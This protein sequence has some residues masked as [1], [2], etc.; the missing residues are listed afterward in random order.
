MKSNLQTLKENHY[1]RYFEYTFFL[2]IVIIILSIL[3]ITRNE[4]YELSSGMKV[5]YGASLLCYLIFHSIYKK[6]KV[7]E[8]GLCFFVFVIGL[9]GILWSVFA[10]PTVGILNPF[11]IA[12]LLSTVYFEFNPLHYLYIQMLNLSIFA[13]VQ[14]SLFF[15]QTNF[16]FNM[17]YASSVL[18]LCYLIVFNRYH[19]I[20]IA[21]ENLDLL[22]DKNKRLEVSNSEIVQKTNELYTMESL[23]G[24][25]VD[26][27]ETRDF[28]SAG[29]SKRVK[30]ISLVIGRQMGL[31]KKNLEELGMI[32]ILHDVGKIGISDSALKKAGKLTGFEWNEIKKHPVCGYNLLK[33]TNLKYKN[34]VAVKHHH[35]RYDGQGYPDGLS[36]EQIPLFSRIIAIADSYDAMTSERVYRK[37]MSHEEA[38]IEIVSNKNKQFDPRLVECLIEFILNNGFEPLYKKSISVFAEETG[39]MSE[40]LNDMV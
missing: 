31:D 23:V 24:V 7:N 8:V 5:V 12:L 40:L 26:T 38:M 36:G 16:Y 27:L 32:S 2:L 6:R 33:K 11:I 10:Q 18:V 25:L 22:A 1:Q 14:F 21:E 9:I 30:E 29:H 13:I 34:I 3:N 35:E 20:K 19:L 39:S 37:A 15:N 28:Y 17:I 4:S